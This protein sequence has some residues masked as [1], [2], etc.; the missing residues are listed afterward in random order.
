MLVIPNAIDI[1]NPTN[2][3]IIT[4]KLFSLPDLNKFGLI[5]LIN[6][7]KNINPITYIIAINTISSANVI[8]TNLNATTIIKVASNDNVTNDTPTKDLANI[9]N[10]I[11]FGLVLNIQ[12]LSPSLLIKDADGEQ[13]I[14]VNINTTNNVVPKFTACPTLFA[15]NS[16][17]KLLQNNTMIG[18]D[19]AIPKYVNR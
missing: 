11:P 2:I 4:L 16:N 15:A 14:D 9:G 18:I 13:I 8:D 1:I 19:N 12:K 5:K 10:L 17:I 7:P 3:C 6:T